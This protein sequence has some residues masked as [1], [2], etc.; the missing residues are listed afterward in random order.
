MY[1]GYNGYK[2]VIQYTCEET[3]DV[4]EGTIFKILTNTL[5]NTLRAKIG[6]TLIGTY[7]SITHNIYKYE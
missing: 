4:L 5:P 2:Q 6:T 1:T 7:K 3:Y